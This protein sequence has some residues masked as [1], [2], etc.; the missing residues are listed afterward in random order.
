MDERQRYIASET[1]QAYN[2]METTKQRHFDLLTA[3]ETKKKKFNLE[4]TA[5]ESQLLKN[6]LRDHDTQV[7]NFK[8]A[9]ES[10]KQRDPETHKALFAYIGEIN[11]VLHDV[12]AAESH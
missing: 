10:L 12:R 1:W 4:P 9:S 2:A 6:L 7:N 3:L 8:L 11:T 5:K